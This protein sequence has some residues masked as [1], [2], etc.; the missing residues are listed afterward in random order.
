MNLW[1][2]F[3][4]NP[5]IWLTVEKLTQQA[6]WLL[7]FVVLARIL[8]PQPYGIFTIAMAFIGFCEVVI[9]G[10]TVEALVTVPD[11]NDGHLRTANLLTVIAATVS[12]IAA[13]AA[14]PLLAKIFDSADLEPVFRTLAVL[15]VI[16]ALT[17]TPIAILTRAM[18]FRALAVRSIF[19]LLAG[20]IVGLF[21]AWYGAGVW[22]LVAQI[23]VQRC[24]ELGLLWASAH[25][26]CSFAWSTP[27]FV[28]MRGYAM[29]V[30]VSKS[31]AWFGSQIPRIIL[32]WYLGP[33]DLGLF[34]LAARIVD[35]VIQIF[36][37]PQAWVARVVLRRFADEP[38]GFA[39][40]FQLLIRQIAV[41][42]F[43]V[44]CGLAAIMPVIFVDFLSQPWRAGIPAAQI[45]ILTGIPA[46]FYYCFTAA[47]LAARQP[48]LDS[49]IAVATDSTTAIAVLL[50]ASHGLYAA[51]I[52]ML[53]QRVA[54]MPAPL[55]MLR[56]ATG[57]SPLT[58]IWAQLPILT[59]AA[60]M[61]LIVVWFTPLVERVTSHSLLMPVLI[62][63]GAFAYL[64]LVTI[65][66]PD[67]VRGT[68][69]RLAELI[70]PNLEPV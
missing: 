26:R 37:V 22:A 32:G 12:A 65:A 4:T 44:C 41:L 30:G 8:G 2:A 38:G 27:H 67:V 36:I 25:S 11:A 3:G 52:A 42:S 68:Y 5:T 48:H 64:P 56:R 58:V 21:L 13:F 43:P 28:D 35:C 70:S 7:L 23:L 60:I 53:L 24:V 14:A 57:I 6:I 45:L 69:R 1:R 46:T 51:C 29:S 40:A 50:V 63:I 15:P 34:A 62:L 33:T 9:V 19:G 17:A 49:Q 54:M 10:A 16:S 39:P 66:A 31:M 18:R 47:V 55:I 20:G 61:A 59:A